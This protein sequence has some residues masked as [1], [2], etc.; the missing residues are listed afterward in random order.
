MLHARRTAPTKETLS[1]A[2]ARRIALAAQGFARERGETAPGRARIV[3]MIERQGVLQ[4]D[5]VNVLVRS[6]YLPLFSR[7]GSYDRDVVDR[8]AYGRKP[9]ALFEYW[10]HMAS[11]LPVALQPLFRWRMERAREGLRTGDTAHFGR[12]RRAFVERALKE[13]AERGPMSASELS[14]SGK[15]KG[16]WWGWSDGKRAME[17]LFWAGLVTTAARRGFERIYDLPERVLPPSILAAPTPSP[18]DAQR[19]LIE[20]GARALGIATEPDLRDYFRLPRAESR[21]RVAELI[22]AGRLLP[23]SIKG[24]GE[25]YYLHA[26]AGRP[27][28]LQAQALL[29]PFDPVVWFRPRAERLFDFH[30]RIGLYTPKHKRTHGYYV[31]PFLLGD[32]LVGRVD[33]KADRQSSTLRVEAAHCEGHCEASEAAPPL[34]D[35]VKRMARWL[36]LERVQV[37]KRGQLAEAL[38][39][40]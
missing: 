39:K 30:Y 40:I 29:T 4:I 17:W 24:F 18:A 20:L 27:R 25:T 15:A 10:G 1:P 9:R 13:V 31:L 2:E 14:E 32:R 38:A 12:K 21:A 22:E 19:Q 26:D 37:A 11:L 16:S 23:V 35:E 7:L 28:R 6:H 3:A 5:S 34:M 36:G 8:L 33:L